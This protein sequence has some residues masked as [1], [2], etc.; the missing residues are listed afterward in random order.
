MS[1]GHSNDISWKQIQIET[2]SN[3]ELLWSQA[4]FLR[5]QLFLIAAKNKVEQEK[6]NGASKVETA[7]LCGVKSSWFLSK[8]WWAKK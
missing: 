5:N 6:K 4:S 8:L 1:Q 3:K 7:G 2:E